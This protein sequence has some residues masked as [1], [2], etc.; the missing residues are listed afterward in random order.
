MIDE[1]M[2][3]EEIYG[4]LKQT[5]ETLVPIYGRV[6]LLSPAAAFACG[7]ALGTISKAKALVGR[8]LDEQAK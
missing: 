8:D 3:P 7:E 5:W 2:T 4:L 6:D 1:P